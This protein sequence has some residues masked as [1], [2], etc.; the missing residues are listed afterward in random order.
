MHKI[1]TWTVLLAS[2][3]P[4]VS[5]ILKADSSINLQESIQPLET[6][7]APMPQIRGVIIPVQ[8]TSLAIQT[9]QGE[10]LSDPAEEA[11]ANV[12]EPLPVSETLETPAVESSNIQT[13]QE[14]VSSDPTQEAPANVQEPLP[15]LETLEK[16]AV[17]SS[18]IQT[19]QE[20]VSSDPTQEA[21]TNVQEP[22][23]APET[24][25][26][27]AVQSSNIQTS[28]EEVS[29]DP[30]HEAST[31]VQEPLPAS[32][33]LETPP[34]ES[35]PLQEPVVPSPQVRGVLVPLQE[36]V[37]EQPA[38]LVQEAPPKVTDSSVSVRKA[39][40]TIIFSA[41]EVSP[42]CQIEVVSENS[43]EKERS[44]LDE[45]IKRNVFANIAIGAISAAVVF[46]S[47]VLA[48]K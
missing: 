34:V 37:L 1:F 32:E 23:P 38:P 31:N 42:S 2:L 28:Q 35:V 7:S 25:E 11:P 30:T 21:S 29:L 8:N 39:P 22:L 46:V 13:S 6:P 9:S 41:P 12:Q 43:D 44:K 40:P 47:A 20:E 27:P 14:E 33:T 24:L 48:S 4:H 15:A 45:P 36:P 3:A 5:C 10:A 17:Q 26:K 16:P 18:N 19:S